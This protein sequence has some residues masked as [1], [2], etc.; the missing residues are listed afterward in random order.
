MFLHKKALY[1]LIK[2]NLIKVPEQ[3]VQLESWQKDN[4]RSYSL[5]TLF[6]SLS[7]IGLSFDSQSFQKAG[8]HFDTPEAFSESLSKQLLSLD[9]DKAYLL[10]FELWR[11]LF[12][13]KQSLTIFCDELDHQIIRYEDE[14]G[15]S[16]LEI[17]DGVVTL[18]DVIDKNVDEGVPVKDALPLLQGFC[19]NNLEAFLYNYIFDRIEEENISYAKE[20]IEGFSKYTKEP[21]FFKLLAI[22][23]EI[24]EDPEE[25]YE[26]LENL[27]D[28]L[29]EETQLEL[30]LDMLAF[31]AKTGNHSLFT[32][33][34][35]QIIP[36]LRTEEDFRDLVLLSVQHFTYVEL[37]VLRVATENLLEKRSSIPLDQILSPSD[38]ALLELQS[39]L[40]QKVHFATETPH[41]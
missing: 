4:Y 31:L 30:S 16:F 32:K 34:A 28:Q 8:Q 1:N 22:R 40:N 33:L 6:S 27:I 21:L 41:S 20:L 29:K 13:E 9:Q 19:A 38:S 15:Q 2:F 17:Q 36:S 23:V 18:Q 37:D 35:I 3:Q 24:S 7:K 11:R 25:G 5:E 39:I 26:K 14:E 10:I 12:P